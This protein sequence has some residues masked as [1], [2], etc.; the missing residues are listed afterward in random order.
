MPM[1]EVTTQ[2]YYRKESENHD[3]K[4]ARN[5]TYSGIHKIKARRR[6]AGTQETSSQYEGIKMRWQCLQ[7]KG[8]RTPNQFRN[9]DNNRNTEDS[10]HFWKV[11]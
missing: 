6:D 4:C 5:T 9:E 2:E 3:K 1:R 8:Y 10:H 7:Y 11:R